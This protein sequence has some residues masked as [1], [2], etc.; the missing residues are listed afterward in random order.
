MTMPPR[1]V[2]NDLA[3]D[4]GF[5]T[6]DVEQDV[7]VCQPAFSTCP[8]LVCIMIASPFAMPPRRASP[9]RRP[10]AIDTAGMQAGGARLAANF[11]CAE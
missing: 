5:P 7:I 9:E 4:R 11:K 2:A 1:I 6:T 3:A 10:E 8:M